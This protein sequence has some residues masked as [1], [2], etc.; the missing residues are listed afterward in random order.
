MI[1]LDSFGRALDR[2]ADQKL[3]WRGTDGVS[4]TLSDWTIRVAVATSN[5][6]SDAAA[7]YSFHKP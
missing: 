5:G 4:A 1:E 2:G 3:S 7:E 6:T